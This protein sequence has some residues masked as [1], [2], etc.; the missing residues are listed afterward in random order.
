MANLHTNE[1]QTYEIAERLRVLQLEQHEQ[2][3][4]VQQLVQQHEQ[5]HEQQQHEEAARTAALPADAAP[6][7]HNLFAVGPLLIFRAPGEQTC[8]RRALL[9]LGGDAGVD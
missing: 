8:H 9:F 4:Q 3:Q 5:Q 2:Q 1:Q 6:R 7:R